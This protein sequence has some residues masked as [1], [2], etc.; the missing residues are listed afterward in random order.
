MAKIV[1]DKN[2]FKTLNKGTHTVRVNFKD[3]HAQ[4]TFEVT[5][6]ITFTI[7]D[8]TF[9]AT[10][11]M[12]WTDWLE[13]YAQASGNGI[14]WVSN[15][16]Q[17]YLDPRYKPSWSEMSNNPGAFEDLLYDSNDVQQTLKSVIV[18]GMV[19]GRSSD[20]PV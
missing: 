15:S 17:L 7:L 4:G 1:I 10:R 18:N 19:Y 12:T 20:C 6:Q 2:Y 9:T 13:S 8:T 3:G 16:A 14:V 11:G 5:D